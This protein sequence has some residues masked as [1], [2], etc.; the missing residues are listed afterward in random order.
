MYKTSDYN[1]LKVNTIML[2]FE[3]ITLFI[4][5]IIGT[6]LFRSGLPTAIAMYLKPDRFVCNIVKAVRY[7]PIK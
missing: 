4:N 1:E 7:V 5:I 2:S 6:S 3:E